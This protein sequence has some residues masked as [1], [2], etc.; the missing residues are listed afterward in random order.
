MLE[1]RN[2]KGSRQ[3]LRA[4]VAASMAVPVLIAPVLIALC[5]CGGKAPVSPSPAAPAPT[6]SAPTTS[7]P[8]AVTTSAAAP[9]DVKDASQDGA[10]T[11][12]IVSGTEAKP[13]TVGEKVQAEADFDSRAASWFAA[14]V[15]GDITARDEAVAELVGAESRHSAARLIASADQIDV[16][17]GAA[18][19]LLER[20]DENDPIQVKGIVAALDDED[21][22]VRRMALQLV[23]RSQR[24]TAEQL[25]AV[26]KLM[27]DPA[28]DKASR[29]KAIRGMAKMS[30]AAKTILPELRQVAAN[31]TEPS[32]R[33]AA[34]YT[35]SRIDPSD[36]GVGCIV[37]RLKNDNA[38][39]VRQL[40]AAR[41][42]RLRSPHSAPALCAAL[43]DGDSK[44]RQSAA[45][46]LGRLGPLAVGPLIE[47]L[48]SAD[49]EVRKLAI[50]ALGKNGAA[51][52]S[53]IPHLER[54]TEV[55]ESA[56]VRKLAQLT[57][58][59]IKTAN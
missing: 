24:L 55:E 42:G 7:A 28:A 8:P 56:E 5:G 23:L 26:A 47:H 11:G 41:L 44:V 22:A 9:R 1:R 36:E 16:R 52:N 53:A 54:L 46:S 31:S 40:A 51:A 33:S 4:M 3:T 18:F 27:S 58:R 50:Y 19:Y 21:A 37:E 6:T 17:R 39:E 13:D 2:V 25:P 34:V 12:G 14:I 43:K 49:T 45:D 57:I 30:E 32:V 38:A 15:S 20:F 48:K 59:V 29:I 10:G 35:L